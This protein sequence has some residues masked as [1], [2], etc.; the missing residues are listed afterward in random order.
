M[1]SARTP[2]HIV[3]MSPLAIIRQEQNQALS[4]ALDAG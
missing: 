1:S 2:D 4:P 3:T